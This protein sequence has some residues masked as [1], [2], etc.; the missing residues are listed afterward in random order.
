M[1][2]TFYIDID[3]EITSIVDRMR[4]S[5]AKEV[6]IVVPKRALIIQSMVNLKLL[7]READRLKK[8]III[9]TQDKLGKLLVEKAGILVQ[10]KMDEIE[11]EEMI[12]DEDEKNL[13]ME[14]I[15]I[16]N[17]PDNRSLQSKLDSIGSDGYFDDNKFNERKI[18][19]AEQKISKKAEEKLINQE[20]VVGIGKDARKKSFFKRSPSLDIVRAEKTETPMVQEEKKVVSKQDFGFP[21]KFSINKNFTQD[22]SELQAREPDTEKIRSFFNNENSERTYK[23]RENDYKNVSVGGK[24]WKFLLVFGSVVAIVVAL[25]AA[26]LFLPKATIIIFAK[27]KSQSVEAEIKGSVNT[28]SVDFTNGNIPAKLVSVDDELTQTFSASGGK[29]STNQKAKGTI[30]IYNEFSDKSQ[31]LV[32]TT[33]FENEGGLIFRLVKSITVPGVT[34]V[35]GETKPG[36]I[37]ADVIA[38]EAGDKYNIGPSSFTI[39]G[40]KGSGNEKYTKF[41]A[42]SFKSMTGGGNNGSTVKAITDADINDAKNKVAAQLNNHIKQK[43]KDSI[44]SENIVLDDA[45]SIGNQTY[46]TSNAEGDLTESF[47]VTVGAKANVLIFSENDVKSILNAKLNASVGNS[48]KSEDNYLTVDYGKA[49]VDLTGGTIIFRVNGQGKIGSTIDTENLKKGILGKNEEDLTAYLKTYPEISKYEI[50]YW[51]PFINGKIP[52]YENR[53]EIKLDNN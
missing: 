47:T 7:K 48:E 41:Y 30:T 18:K 11:G 29:N 21:D 43:T 6:V 52:S 37:E 8:E 5:E 39:P 45:I 22:L 19:I 4:K 16:K 40:F 53:V 9:V 44:G 27:N 32:A 31:S 10:Q 51:P 3:E 28:T 38:D 35:S 1:H 15:M 2:Q 20:L 36:A 14:N 24:V 50:I 49:D 13:P 23:K 17:N 34:Q 25:I 46:K 33:R 26:Y 12:F 42:K